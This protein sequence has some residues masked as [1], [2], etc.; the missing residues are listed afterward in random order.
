MHESDNYFITSYYKLDL[1]NSLGRED[2]RAIMDVTHTEP[3]R[4]GLCQCVSS[5]NG[6]GGF[7]RSQQMHT[8]KQVSMDF[9]NFL[10]PNETLLLI[11]FSH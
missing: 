5:M 2:R 7:R 10:T 1:G 8:T 3:Y 11:P 4:T 6:L 9:R